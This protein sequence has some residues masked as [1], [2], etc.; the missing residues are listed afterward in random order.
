MKA[1]KRFG[2][3]FLKDENIARRI[4]DALQFKQEGQKTK[5]L[6][7]GGGTGMLTQFLLMREEY[8]VYV[9]EVERAA[10]EFLKERFPQLGDHLIEGDFLRLRLDEMFTYP[11]PI[12]G[13]I[14][15]NI[16][17]PIF[18]RV[19]DYRDLVP[20]AVFMIQKEVAQRIVAQPGTKDY[21]V[22]TVMIRT[23]YETKYLFNVPPTAFRPQP[24]VTSAVVRLRRKAV[25]PP[26]EDYDFYRY[27]VKTA[28][29][30]RRKTV[31][32]SLKNLYNIDLVPQSILD[33]R[34]EQLS[35]EEFYELARLAK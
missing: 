29:G 3:H 22:L 11:L 5:L 4:A 34:A 15:Y 16:T 1:K 23:F 26:I 31:R 25:D 13:N 8:E 19:L 21:S 6:E 28:F 32:N 35:L 14:P 10:I 12:I 9:V 18:F 30:Q 20:E 7:I 27:V 17:G 24:R 2:Q 33:K